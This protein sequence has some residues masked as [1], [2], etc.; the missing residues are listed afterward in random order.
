MIIGWRAMLCA[1][2]VGA[3]LAI[4]GCATRTAP[5]AAQ[6]SASSPFEQPLKD[7]S[8]VRDAAPDVLTQAAASPY[9]AVFGCAELES[10]LA[11]LDVALGPDIDEAQAKADGSSLVSDL[12]TGAIGLPYRGVIRK[13]TGA[14]ARDRAFKAAVLSGMVRRGFLKGSA[15]RQGCWLAAPA[16]R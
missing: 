14:E 6:R 15:V 8:L 9:L 1:L 2:L 13:V 3:G 10:E 5:S 11:R 7:L 12:I 4:A 16:P